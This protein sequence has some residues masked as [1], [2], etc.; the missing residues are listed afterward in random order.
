MLIDVEPGTGMERVTNGREGTEIFEKLGFL[1]R[2]EEQYRAIFRGNEPWS[3]LQE[4]YG[5]LDT[6][7]RTV[8]GEG[9]MDEVTGRILDAVGDVLVK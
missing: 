2:V 8:D 6:E 3:S 1:E 7:L 5:F 4:D 9:T